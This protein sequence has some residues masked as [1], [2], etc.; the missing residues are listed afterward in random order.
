MSR[1][2]E[3]ERE[4]ERESERERERVRESEKRCFGF[5]FWI[6]Y[7]VG[8]FWMLQRPLVVFKWLTAGVQ[9]LKRPPRLMW[10]F[11]RYLLREAKAPTRWQNGLSC[12]ELLLDNNGG[13]F[14]WGSISLLVAALVPDLACCIFKWKKIFS[15]NQNN[16]AFI[17]DKCCHLTLCFQSC[18]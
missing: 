8:G 17:L 10:A 7:N 12:D 15:T 6:L 16:K 9:T 5:Q 2:R 14:Q 4:W 13:S 3:R 11:T 18:S 1:E